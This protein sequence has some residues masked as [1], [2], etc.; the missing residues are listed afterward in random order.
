MLALITYLALVAS[1]LFTALPANGF[2]IISHHGMV[3]QR[4][5][6]IIAPNGTSGHTH[7]FVGSAAILPSQDE[8]QMCTTSTVKA[9]LS[10]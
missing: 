4:L 3:A 9:D 7:N 2:W 8:D 10:K 1:V 6:P 5:D